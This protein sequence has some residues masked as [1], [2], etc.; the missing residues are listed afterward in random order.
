MRTGGQDA[1]RAG[2]EV[3]GRHGT[4][5]FADPGCKAHDTGYGHP[6]RPERYDA[7]MGALSADGLA[8]RLA[9]V[10]SEPVDDIHVLTC[11]TPEYLALVRHDLAQGR[12][13]LSTG[14]T[15]VGPGSLEVARNTAGGVLGAVDA[16][17]G[18]DAKN[19]F[20][21]ARPPGHHACRERGMGFCILNNI[22]LAARY[23][24]TTYGL[25][26]VM[27][28]DWDVHHGNGTQDVFYD[29]PSVFFFSTH[30]FPWYPGTG[31]RTE[32]GIGMA[33]GTTLNCP[34]PAGSSGRDILDAFRKEAVPAADS[35]QPELVL[36]SAGFDAHEHDPLGRFN[37]HAEHFAELT[38][39]AMAIA[40]RHAG[41]RAVSVLEGGYELPSLACSARAHVE[42]LTE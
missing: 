21:L 31:D 1:G 38:S 6:E 11:H 32:R 29:D 41:G 17:C 26:K 40:D 25:R 37:L 7:V 33:K 9:R 14:D 34:L 16:V 12:D 8:D 15:S 36:I 28:L 19:A 24:Q 5:L 13:M 27:I 35:F 20:C 2:T 30:Q 22:A 39:I 23:A 10:V 42:T 3:G 18:G 4:A